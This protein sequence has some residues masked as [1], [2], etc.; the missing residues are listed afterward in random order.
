M[1]RGLPRDEQRYVLDGRILHQP[2]QAPHVV[3][4][5]EVGLTHGFRETAHG[6]G[7]VC[8]R[9]RLDLRAFPNLSLN[10]MHACLKPRASLTS[11]PKVFRRESE[12]KMCLCV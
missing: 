6:V 11:S 1:S 2:A 9:L 7:H 10:V 4:G 3:L 8:A 12:G 5:Q